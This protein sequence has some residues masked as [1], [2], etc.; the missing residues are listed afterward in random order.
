MTHLFNVIF[1]LC[2]VLGML[3]ILFAV[4]IKMLALEAR[5]T[6]ASHTVFLIAGTFF[7]AALAT[8]EV[9]RPLSS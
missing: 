3:S 8:R 9:Q 4:L 1:K 7:L 5:L 2:W 6:V